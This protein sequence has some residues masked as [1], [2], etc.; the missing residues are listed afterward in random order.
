MSSWDCTLSSGTT[1]PSTITAAP[2]WSGPPQPADQRAGGQHGRDD[3]THPHTHGEHPL[4]AS[5]PALA[6][7]AGTRGHSRTA[8]RPAPDRC[9]QVASAASRTSP[10]ARCRAAAAPADPA[11][12][13][14]PRHR[15]DAGTPACR[16]AFGYSRCSRSCAESGSVDR[17][18]TGSRCR[19]PPPRRRRAPG[20]T[21]G[22]R[23]PRA[24]CAPARAARRSGRRA[25]RRWR[26][27]PPASAASAILR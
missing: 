8:S 23:R 24:G 21:A 25:P 13:D 20:R 9:E 11:A 19:P 4:T 27:A 5:R 10:A 14:R 12:L 22:T 2:A 3:P 7:R 6:G 1:S 18:R 17:A 26:P 15:D 16:C